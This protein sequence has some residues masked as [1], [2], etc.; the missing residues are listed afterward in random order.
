M[1]LIDDSRFT[2]IIMCDQT[3]SAISRSMQTKTTRADQLFRSRII[4]C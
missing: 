1:E 2:M 3:R 4:S